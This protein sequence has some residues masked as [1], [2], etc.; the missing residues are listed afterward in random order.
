MTEITSRAENLLKLQ[1]T[2]KDTEK[3]IDL[4]KVWFRAQANGETLTETV[5]GL[6]TVQVKK[7]S[8]GKDTPAGIN[9]TFSIDKFKELDADMQKLLVTKGVV[10]KTPFAATTGKVGTAAVEITLNV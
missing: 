2:Y 5:P 7:P 9:Y 1:R 8:V 6:G 10:T 3:L 4:E